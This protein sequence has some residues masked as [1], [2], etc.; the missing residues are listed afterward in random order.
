MK[1]LIFHYV[2]LQPLKEKHIIKKRK[3]TYESTTWALPSLC[4]G[5][6]TYVFLEHNGS[7]ASETRHNITLLFN[8]CSEIAATN[9][10]ILTLC[11]NV[12]TKWF[13]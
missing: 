10:A 6:Y 13:E 8:F 1:V 9:S 11:D 3:E 4:L 5:Q 12:S 2:Q 7:H